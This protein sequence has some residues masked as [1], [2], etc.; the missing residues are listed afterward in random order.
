[1]N[2]N[3]AR[4]YYQLFIYYLRGIWLVELILTDCT[5]NKNHTKICSILFS[6]ARN[7]AL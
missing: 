2:K 1:V 3:I 6:A 4:E 5:L 7:Y